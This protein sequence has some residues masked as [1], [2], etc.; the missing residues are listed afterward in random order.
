V[1]VRGFFEPQ[2][3]AVVGVSEAPENLGRR[4]AM[5]LQEFDFDGIV[6]LVGP[7]GGRAFGRRI[8]K[9]VS[10]IPDQVDLAVILVPARHVPDIIDECGHKGIRRAII[11]SA[12]FSELGPEGR[13]AEQRLLEAARRHGMRFIGPNCIGVINRGNG[14]AVPFPVLKNVFARGGISI[15]TQSG[16]VGL[17]YLNMLASENLG[18]ARFASIGNKLDVDECDLLEFLV[19]DE[20]TRIICLYLESISDGRRLMRIARS[21]DK[22]ILLHKSNT[23]TLAQEIAQ[24]HTAALSGDDAVVSAALEQVG[25]ARFSTANTLLNFLKV[26]PL[27]PLRGKQVAVLSRSGG[28]AVIAADACEQYGFSLVRFPEDF[29]RA[30]EQHFRAQVIRLT[31]PLD[32]G[33]LF[34][35]DVYDRIVERTLGLPQVDGMIFLH[36]YVSAVERED[37]RAF[38]RRLEEHSFRQGKPVAT[39]VFTDSEEMSLLRRT[40]PHPVFTTPEDAVRALALLRD[41][42]HQQL[43]EPRADAS[44]IDLAAIRTIVERCRAEKRP[45][46]LDEGLEILRAAGLPVAAWAVADSAAQAAAAA[47]EFGSPVALKLIAPEISHKTDVGGV[48]VGV[49]GADWVRRGFERLQQAAREAGVRNPP[50]VL[51]QRMV[52]GGTEMIIGAKRD[53]TFGPTVLAGAGGIFVEV[54]RDV[55]L[56]VV[57]LGDGDLDDMLG[58]LRVLPLLE[59]ARG[60]KPRDLEALRECVRQVA[61][62][63]AA[64]PEIAELDVNP[65]LVLHQGQGAVAVDARVV[66]GPAERDEDRFRGAGANSATQV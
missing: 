21:T 58:R 44:G 39:C 53:P 42:R 43:P 4:I 40:L 6:Y 65:L 3:V 1:P 64:C 61:E 38:L 66:L 49:E 33:D 52:S 37:S 51:V 11:E 5:N 36:T 30:I 60:R 55:A 47:Q 25:I 29:L 57:P 63:A 48:L 14:L 46:L 28:H 54:L 35:Y 34:D 22:P 59:G 8:Y 23:G 45:V 20:Q 13:Q 17:D 56:K 50:R 31:N 9:S 26:L 2:S 18:L 19:A 15:V 7:R 27:P 24:S 41:Y 10:D 16:G 62:L 32:L 12:G